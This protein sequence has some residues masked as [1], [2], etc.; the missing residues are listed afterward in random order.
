MLKNHII[1]GSKLF[2]LLSIIFFSVAMLGAEY[3]AVYLA[4]GLIV[5]G[6]FTMLISSMMREG[7]RPRT[8]KQEDDLLA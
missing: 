4:L 2:V 7:T 1:N 8:I 6:G 3:R 5:I